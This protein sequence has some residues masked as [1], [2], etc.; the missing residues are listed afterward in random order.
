[1]KFLLSALM[2][3]SFNSF[4]GVDLAKS[5]FKWVGKKIAGPHSGIVPLKSASLV[6]EKDQIK[7]GEFVI[8]LTQLTVT[9]LEGDMKGKLEGHL[10]SPDFF[11]VE[12]FPT[13]TLRVKSA[14]KNTVKAD[15]TIKGKTH[16]VKFAVKQEGTTYTGVLKFDRT[17]FDM[18]YNSGNFFKDLGDKVINNEVTVEFK[19]VQN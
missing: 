1:M 8:D 4:A 19:V 16:P 3:L 15:L 12:K 9:D 18:I 14:N 2:V 5:E 7:G 13:A 17:K 10:K 6:V 11:N